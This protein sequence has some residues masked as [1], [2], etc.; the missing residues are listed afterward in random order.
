MLNIHDLIS[1][2][3]VGVPLMVLAFIAVYLVFF[4]ES[5]HSHKS[6]S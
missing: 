6:K 4:R 1:G 3:M 2:G 5:D